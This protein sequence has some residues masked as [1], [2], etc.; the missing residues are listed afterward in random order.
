[1]LLANLASLLLAVISV[2][3]CAPPRCDTYRRFPLPASK[4]A[5]TGFVS[6]H[7]Q[8]LLNPCNYSQS[9]NL[10]LAIDST[11]SCTDL[12]SPPSRYPGESCDAASE[13]LGG[14]PCF[15]GFCLGKRVTEV[16]DRD[17]D[18][19]PGLHCVVSTDY[20]GVCLPMMGLNETCDQGERCNVFLTCNNGI[21]QKI[22]A[23]G[24]G[25]PA[26]NAMACDSFYIENGL[27]AVGPK[28]R[29]KKG[30]EV[31]NNATG[32]EECGPE[33]ICEYFTQSGSNLSAP[34]QCGKTESGKAFCNPG[35][36]D[37]DMTPVRLGRK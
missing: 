22:G 33:G 26:T 28:L 37:L 31:N 16:C 23:L 2:V 1:M 27:C 30:K 34:C 14:R 6:G 29:R 8:F 32:P 5:Q 4:C 13:C 20:P 10:S 18:C 36:G 17:E 25:Q 11:D 21:C 24:I 35:R 9:C 15:Q 7:Y 19:G 12:H 3:V